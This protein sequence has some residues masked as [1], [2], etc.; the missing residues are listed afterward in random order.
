MFLYKKKWIEPFENQRDYPFFYSY[1][2]IWA[3]KAVIG[4]HSIDALE[5][6]VN[7]LKAVEAEGGDFDDIVETLEELGNLASRR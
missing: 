6:V 5:N 7:R 4:Q 2:F 1:R 3:P